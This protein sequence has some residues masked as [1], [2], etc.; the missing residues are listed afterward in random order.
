VTDEEK[1]VGVGDGSERPQ[2]I[3]N[4]GHDLSARPL[5]GRGRLDDFADRQHVGCE[6]AGV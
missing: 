2:L 3:A 4:R 1:V 6:H 5:G